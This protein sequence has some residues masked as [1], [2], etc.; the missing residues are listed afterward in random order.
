MFEFGAEFGFKTY[1]RFYTRK[2]RQWIY[3][4]R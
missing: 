3:E 4:G 1:L 2:G